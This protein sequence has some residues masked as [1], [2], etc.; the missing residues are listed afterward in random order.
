MKKPKLLDKYAQDGVN[1]S[2]GDDFSSFCGTLCRSTYKNS[3]FVEIHDF[4]EGQFRGPRGWKFV[5]LPDGC[6]TTGTPDGIGTKTT[7]ID[8]ANMYESSA[9]N[10]VEMTFTDMTRFGGFPLLFL[11]VL[12]VSSLGRRGSK[13]DR[14]AT[15]V[16][17]GLKELADREG[18]V[19]F[20]GETAE[21][22]PCVGS[23]NPKAAL[24]YN[25]AGMAVGVY[26]PKK[27]ITGESLRPGQVVIAL[28]DSF[29]SNGFS[30]LR[31]ALEAHFGPG[32]WT[33]PKVQK[34][35]RA[36]AE[37]AK[38]Y[39]KFLAYLNGWYRTG[40]LLGPIVRVHYVA[41]LT[42]GGI[43]TKF[44]KDG[45]QPRGL[46]ANLSDLH[47]P[48]QIMKDCAKWRGLSDPEC[49]TTF[50]GGQGLL[51]VV[52]EDFVPAVLSAA[53]FY[54]LQAKVAGVIEKKRR[55]RVKIRSQFTGKTFEFPVRS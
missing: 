9:A 31:K 22:G 27:M 5:G 18:F 54:E 26:H 53:P 1:R 2:T 34:A 19:M 8:A 40:G 29:R 23:P 6:L 16:M 11:N 33:D 46:S 32:F 55:P 4:S 38:V 3:R 52:D 47:E 44:F 10:V 28:K 45:L 14:R 39:S 35:L 48:P 20:S 36:A 24:K 17:M 41:H 49:Y 51:L 50:N 21:L 37:P 42:G 25:W 13:A 30:S 7:I 43:E 15:R 12:D